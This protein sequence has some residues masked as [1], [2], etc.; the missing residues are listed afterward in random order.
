[1]IVEEEAE[2]R[3]RR[4]APLSTGFLETGRSREESAERGLA[5]GLLLPSVRGKIDEDDDLSAADSS[6]FV[7]IAA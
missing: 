6:A 7:Y 4:G 5:I 1:M 3:E 2:D